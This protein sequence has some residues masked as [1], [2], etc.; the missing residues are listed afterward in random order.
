MPVATIFC[1]WLRRSLDYVSILV[2]PPRAKSK[3]RFDRI[4]PPTFFLILIEDELQNTTILVAKI[5]KFFFSRYSHF[6]VN[7][8]IQ[9]IKGVQNILPT[10]GL[11]IIFESFPKRIMQDMKNI[12]ILYI[13]FGIIMNFRD[14]RGEFS[15][16]SLKGG[17]FLFWQENEN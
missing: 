16:H 7:L 10:Q 2:S 9:K 12:D 13:F 3:K 6:S 5:R 4:Q 11:Y 15:F 8:C 1:F 17:T 14:F